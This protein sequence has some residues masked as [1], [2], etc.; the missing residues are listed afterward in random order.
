MTQN[1]CLIAQAL[2]NYA[3]LG[4]IERCI[5]YKIMCPVLM[6]HIL[7]MGFQVLECKT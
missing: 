2:A 7:P 1:F 5:V 6:Y 3:K 4:C